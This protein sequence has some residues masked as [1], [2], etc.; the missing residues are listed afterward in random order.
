MKPL[1][2]AAIHCE[3]LNIHVDM[4]RM[5]NREEMLIMMKC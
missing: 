4:C 5:T 3:C 2:V 1:V